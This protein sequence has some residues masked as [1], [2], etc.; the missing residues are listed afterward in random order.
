MSSS[1]LDKKCSLRN[2]STMSSF[3]V[4]LLEV[5][6]VAASYNVSTGVEGSFTAATTL[7]VGFSA[8][9]TVKL[10]VETAVA[11]VAGSCMAD[12]RRRCASLPDTILWLALLVVVF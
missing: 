11:R 12:L 4:S 6:T 5:M 7:A 2:S 3:S 1:L 8:S 9:G 10:D